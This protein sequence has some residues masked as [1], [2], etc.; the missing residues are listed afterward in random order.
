MPIVRRCL[1]ALVIIWLVAAGALV[2]VQ[3]FRS[4]PEKFIK[5]VVEHPLRGLDEAGRATIIDKAARLLNGLSTDQRREVKK[6]GTL[7]TFFTELTTEE[8]RR[9]ARLTLP[10]GFRQ[11]IAT[12]NGMEPD[13]RKKVVQRTLRDL[14]ST[15]VSE[16][17]D[18]SDMERM[19]SEGASIFYE[20][21]SP[22][23]LLDFAP[24]IEAAQKKQ[25]E[26]AV[27]TALPK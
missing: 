9:F 15:E 11:M 26:F 21:A 14:N 20:E 3:W 25:K 23:V 22:Q 17:G 1:L 2:V 5:H 24:V 19:F 13:Q 27:R 8:R 16:F 10:K 4:T 7:R 18:E 12:L 6:S